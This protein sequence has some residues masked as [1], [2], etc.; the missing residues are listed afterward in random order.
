MINV[1][2]DL[3]G[4]L[5]NFVR[6]VYLYCSAYNNLDMDYWEFSKNPDEIVGEELMEYL[7]TI[8][9]I[10]QTCTPNVNDLN[11]INSLKEK[12]EFFY[13][14]ARPDSIRL[15]TEKFLTINKFPN[16]SN[17]YFTK[18]KGLYTRILSLDYFIDDMAKYVDKIP[19]PT[20]VFL[21][22]TPWNQKDREGKNCIESISKFIKLIGEEN[23]L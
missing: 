21:L 22:N 5:Y 4:V 8:P 9:T 14:T 10:Y 20:K 19:K 17:L 2:L 13:I 15:V 7:V 6:A 1:G 3:D 16:Y 12:A 18:D 23:G 11:A